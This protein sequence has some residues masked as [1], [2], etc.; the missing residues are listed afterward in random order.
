ML[1]LRGSEASG[2]DERPETPPPA[3][4]PPPPEEGAAR[5]ALHDVVHNWIPLLIVLVSVLAAVMGWRAS[6]ADEHSA[7]SEELS[8]QDLVQQQQLVVR[9][10]HA[11]D[12]DVQTFGQFAQYSALAHSLRQDSAKV[13]GTL[14]DQLQAEAQSDLG[15]ARYL[16]K[17]IVYQNYSFDPS[18]PTGNPALRTD[19]TYVPG[20]PY[21]AAEALDSA[22]NADTALHG[23][24]PEQLHAT[25]EAEHKRG[26]EFTGVAALFVSI[27]VLLTIA[28]LI[29][30]PP[31]VWLTASGAVLVVVGLV[32]FVL[33]GGA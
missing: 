7:H 16:G 26:V 9:D 15:I 1:E 31:K 10:N 19:G 29:K 22:E 23:L 27:M 2:D 25:A 14:R 13:T 33:V 32:L 6:L 3:A 30:G 21:K 11:I 18:N 12:T 8:R 24:A 17:Q 5:K 28:A 4:P 20:H